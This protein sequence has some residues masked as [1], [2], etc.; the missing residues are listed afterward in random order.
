MKKNVVITSLI[1]VILLLIFNIIIIKKNKYSFWYNKDYSNIL[2]TS[3]ILDLNYSTFSN[4]IVV[5]TN[6]MEKFK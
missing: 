5:Q 3:E 1:I 6:E 2:L 4:S